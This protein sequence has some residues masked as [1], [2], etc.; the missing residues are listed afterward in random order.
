MLR[1]EL[2]PFPF[3]CQRK[4]ESSASRQGR[5]FPFEER[6]DGRGMGARG[7]GGGDHGTLACIPNVE[8]PFPRSSLLKLPPLAAKNLTGPARS[9]DWATARKPLTTAGG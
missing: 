9:V 8:P 2:G 3:S 5:K 4:V 1:G 7:K 6:G